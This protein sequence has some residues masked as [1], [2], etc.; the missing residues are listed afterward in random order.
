MNEAAWSETA[1]I[2]NEMPDPLHS[3]RIAANE[4]HGLHNGPQ[5]VL[6]RTNIAADAYQLRELPPYTGREHRD[7]LQPRLRKREQVPLFMISPHC[8][9]SEK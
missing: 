3:Q 7:V 2:A 8:C 9:K 4:R 6:F 1:P 5:D